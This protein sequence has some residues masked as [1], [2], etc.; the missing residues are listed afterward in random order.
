MNHL[1]K[2]STNNVRTVWHILDY[3]SREKR[4]DGRSNAKVQENLIVGS[5]QK[6]SLKM[7]IDFNKIIVPRDDLYDKAENEGMVSLLID[8]YKLKC[9]NV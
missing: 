2:V 1:L 9:G 8:C 4:W 6:F 7:E 3:K 5:R